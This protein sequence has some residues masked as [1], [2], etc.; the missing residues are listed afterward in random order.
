MSYYT[1]VIRSVKNSSFYVGSTE[2]L[3]LRLSRHNDGWTR[4]TRARRP[5]K[6]VY[7]EEYGTKTKAL[8][9]ER[10]IKRM[11]SR[12]YIRDLISH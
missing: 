8:D 5:W 6:L 11:K 3:M 1:Y 7:F 10:E 4:S 2:D 12:K 9:R